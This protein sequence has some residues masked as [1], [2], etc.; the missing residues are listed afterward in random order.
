VADEALQVSPLLRVTVSRAS[1]TVVVEPA[2]TR[3]EV[4]HNSLSRKR[5]VVVEPAQ[6]DPFDSTVCVV[7]YGLPKEH[8]I[9]LLS[10]A[11]SLTSVWA[12]SLLQR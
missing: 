1:V 10:A 6:V 7:V 2:S 4:G 9:A 12:L 11:S 5:I 8:E 3:V